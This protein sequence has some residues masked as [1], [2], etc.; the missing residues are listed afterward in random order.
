MPHLARIGPPKSNQPVHESNYP[1]FWG[2]LAGLSSLTPLT[3]GSGLLATVSL[4]YG[5][6]LP[7]RMGAGKVW[8]VCEVAG[9]IPGPGTLG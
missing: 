3:P 8:G 9:S 2:A 7:G 6:S 1:S 4:W 5:A